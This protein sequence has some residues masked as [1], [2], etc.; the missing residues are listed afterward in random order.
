MIERAVAEGRCICWIRNTVDD[1]MLVYRQLQQRGKIPAEAL[2]LFHS[3]FAFV[4]RLRVEQTTLIG[5]VKM[6]IHNSDRA[7]CSLPP[8]SLNRVWI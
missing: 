2:L 7:K 8:V 4:D 3:R 6:P 5:L 1:A